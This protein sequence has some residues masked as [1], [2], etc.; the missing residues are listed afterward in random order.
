MIE[1]KKRISNEF[2]KKNNEQ[3]KKYINTSINFSLLLAIPL[4]FGVFSISY[5]MIPW[6]LGD[7]YSDVIPIMM[8]LS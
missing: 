4:M 5:T 2:V 8:M 7:N 1:E 3:I 6:F